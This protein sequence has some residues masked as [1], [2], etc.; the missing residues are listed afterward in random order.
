MIRTKASALSAV[1]P[2]TPAGKR[3]EAADMTEGMGVPK[4]PIHVHL[5]GFRPDGFLPG[6]K[7]DI[8]LSIEAF[9]QLLEHGATSAV[10][11]ANLVLTQQDAQVQDS[12]G[13]LN[14]K[15]IVIERDQSP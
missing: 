1:R 5:V 13:Q 4:G 12:S 14:I 9:A 7:I 8:R 6:A 2:S 10:E 15:E 11:T 3:E